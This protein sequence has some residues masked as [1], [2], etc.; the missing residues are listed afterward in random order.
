M[1]DDFGDDFG[2]PDVS[3]L[4]VSKGIATVITGEEASNAVINIDSPAAAA[5]AVD[6]WSLTG[7]AAPALPGQPPFENVL[8]QFASY[9]PLWTLACLTPDQYN[10]P[11][12]YRGNPSALQQ[13][14]FSS[15]GR[16]D[17]QRTQ[18]VVGAP[19][20]FVNNFEM[21]MTTAASEK[22]GLTNMINMSFDVYE[23]Y[24]MTYFLQSIQTAAIECGYPN[25]NGTPFLLMLEFA[26]HR[27]NGQM[28]AS[29]EELKKYFVIQIK[30]V[31]FSTNEGGTT[32]KVEAVPYNHT[33]FTNVAQQITKDIK[34]RGE[35]VKEML[36]AGDMSLCNVLNNAEIE[37][38]KSGKQLTADKYL[39]VF[40]ENWADAVGLPGE[41]DIPEE[42]FGDAVVDPEEPIS[43]PLVGRRGQNTTN[44]GI[45]EI[46]RSSLGFGATS[47]GNFSFGFEGDTVDEASGLVVR[48]SLKIDPKQREFQFTKGATVQNIVQQIILSSE[49]AKHALD[50]S[51]M[52]KETGRI[53]WFRI[54]VQIE[55][56]PF[57]TQRGLRQ[58]TYIFRVMP[59][60]VHSSVF[61][62]PGTNP[63]GYKKLNE[64]CAKEYHY[65]YTG[66]NN[67][68][69]K[70]DIQINQLFNS[71]MN[72][73]PL[74]NT[75]TAA[76]PSGGQIGEDPDQR[77]LTSRAG[78]PLN[79][80]TPDSAPMMKDSE[81][82]KKTTKGGYGAETVPQKVAQMLLNKILKQGSTGDLTKVNLEIIGD[83]YWITDSGMGNYVGS[84]YGEEGGRNQGPY[85]MVDGNG[86]LNYQGSDIYIRII[87]ATPVEPN[88]GTSGQ[89]GLYSF[90][91]GKINPYSGLYKVIH[92]NSSFRDGK[93]TQVLECSRMPNQPQDFEGGYE[94]DFNVFPNDISLADVIST[95]PNGDSPEYRDEAE[96]LN[97]LFGDMGPT[98]DPLTDEEIA[99]N[100][101]SLG[102]FPG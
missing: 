80:T 13:I 93:F 91:K 47:A 62:A 35:N 5:K 67:N 89:G 61:R 36:T 100:N 4:N 39:V 51:K 69:I 46:G 25:Y 15:A 50:P 76:N 22:T 27:D 18:T 84:F 14:I 37:M 11:Q 23:P 73:T 63:P 92:C 99:A 43:S 49:Y 74:E 66:K 20:Y 21:K 78:D 60:Y 12:L 44:F 45:G 95:S 41:A 2:F 16:F 48:G 17:S 68:V 38:Q 85:V 72:P 59:F 10:N 33:G 82:T 28:F 8:D 94:V 81:I 42:L 52:D 55:I 70:F 87:F 77:D 31:T 65:I 56:G 53:K 71:G 54:D 98:G 30:K 75:E 97:L 90:P 9:A 101:A 24:S 19:E 6:Y 96:D 32:Y 7:M 26:G 3:E 34:I 64:L 40:P 102:D 79:Q 57:D 1:Y 88:L 86:G 83:P 58:R 29:T